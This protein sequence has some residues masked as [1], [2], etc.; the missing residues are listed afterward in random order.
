LHVSR[1]AQGGVPKVAE[2][3]CTVHEIAAI[4]GHASL[5]EVERYTK[6]FDRERLARTAMARLAAPLQINKVL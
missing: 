2:A 6:A 5:R 3:G 4:S 1:A